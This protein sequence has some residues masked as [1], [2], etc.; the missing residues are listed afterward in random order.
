MQSKAIELTRLTRVAQDAKCFMAIELTRLTQVAQDAKHFMALGTIELTRLT[1]VAQ[2]A[3]CFMALGAI[4]LN[5]LTWVAQDAKY[6]MALGAIELTRAIECNRRQ[7]NSQSNSP[8]RLVWRRMPS[9]A[10]PG[11]QS[12]S[13]ELTYS[14]RVVQDAKCCM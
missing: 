12:K 1:R 4:E 9:I 8:V 10:W 11:D 6:F 14:I 7:S 2:D 13:I 5:R 3:K